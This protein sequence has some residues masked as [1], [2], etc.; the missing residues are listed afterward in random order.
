MK[1]NHK[2][3][4]KPETCLLSAARPAQRTGDLNNKIK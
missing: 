3:N 1:P 4:T 2:S